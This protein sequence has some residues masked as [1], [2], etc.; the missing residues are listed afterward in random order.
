[1]APEGR[2]ILVSLPREKDVALPCCIV[3]DV[4]LDLL[5][6]VGTTSRKSCCSFEVQ[7]HHDHLSKECIR[8]VPL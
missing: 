5:L 7:F 1:M 4:D 3:A 2:V 6:F 8:L